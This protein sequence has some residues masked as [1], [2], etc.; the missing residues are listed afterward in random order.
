MLGR[1]LMSRG[2]TDL[3]ETELRAAAEQPLDPAQPST[4]AVL[5][6]LCKV[7][8]TRRK[9]APGRGVDL[10]ALELGLVPVTEATAH[11]IFYETASRVY[12][13]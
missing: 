5:D 2:L 8:S 7:G 13:L 9:H 4:H 11:Q 3:A 6:Q 12:R 1:L 10:D